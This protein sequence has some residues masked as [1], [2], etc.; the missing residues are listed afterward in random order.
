LTLPPWQAAAQRHR[1]LTWTNWPM[2]DT[3]QRSACSR[4]RPGVRL[5]QCLR[6]HA[7]HGLDH[8]VLE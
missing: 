8:L 6:E 5:Q 1:K 2:I 3:T 7:L 4:R